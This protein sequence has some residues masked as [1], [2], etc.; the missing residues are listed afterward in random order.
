MENRTFRALLPAAVAAL[1]H[2]CASTPTEPVEPAR[3]PAPVVEQTAP[4]PKVPPQPLILKPD[5]P[6]RYVVQKGD[7]LWDI[8]EKFLRDPWRWPELW[9]QNTYIDNPHLIYPGDVLSLIYIDGRPTLQVQR[10][11]PVRPTVRLSPKV[12]VEE[13]DRAIPTIPID[14][15]RPFLQRPRVV[16]EEELEAAPYILSTADEHLIAATGNRIYVRGVEDTRAADYVVVRKGQVY[17]NPDDPDEVLGYEAIH[18]ADARV[19]QFGDPATMVLSDSRR[20]ALNGDRLLPGSEERI[21]TNFVPHAP[22]AD[23]S[24]R[25]VAVV[26]GV[27]QIG[28]YQVVA[29]N[30]GLRDGIEA[31]HVLSVF[32]QGPTVTDPVTGDKLALPD[33]RAGVLMIFR[34]F[35]KMSYALIMDATRPMHVLDRVSKP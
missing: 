4:A 33:E 20:E 16:G 3:E 19:L 30:L 5:Y 26:D 21:T 17:R 10:T 29:V 12:R 22:N 14:A 35:E 27:S 23:V 1:L 15:I 32:Q 6:E 24:G 11:E 34:P 13:L 18:V 2:G 7:T 31:G 8:S 9:Q 28:Q 25:I